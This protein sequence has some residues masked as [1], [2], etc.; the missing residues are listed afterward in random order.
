MNVQTYLMLKQAISAAGAEKFTRLAKNKYLKSL[1]P[2]QTDRIINGNI[3]RFGLKFDPQVVD[4]SLQQAI[5]DGINR[6]TITAGYKTFGVN[7]PYGAFMPAAESVGVQGASSIWG[8]QPVKGLKRVNG[9]LALGK[10]DVAQPSA[11]TN[12]W[13]VR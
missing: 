4:G 3:R 8:M 7:T 9:R 2:E 11:F 10:V 6:G 12:Y 5:K 13:R 1:L